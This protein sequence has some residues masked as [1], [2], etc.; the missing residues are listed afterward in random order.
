MFNLISTN[1]VPGPIQSIGRTIYVFVCLCHRP[2]PGTVRT[3]V[4]ESFAKFENQRFFLWIYIYYPYLF[5]LN[6]IAD[7]CK[8]DYCK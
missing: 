6:T 4:K 2:G 7:Y 1:S 3:L 5:Q 8:T